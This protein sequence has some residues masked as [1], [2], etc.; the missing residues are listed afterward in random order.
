ME[1]PVPQTL[2]KRLLT[3]G[4]PRRVGILIATTTAAGFFA[5]HRWE[6][7]LAGASLFLI[8]NLLHRH[9]DWMFEVLIRH[10]RYHNRYIP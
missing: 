3:F 9:D 4:L 6:V 2:T 1:E 7:F 8:G 10:I 5:L